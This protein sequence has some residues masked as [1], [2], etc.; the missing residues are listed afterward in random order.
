MTRANPYANFSLMQPLNTFAT[1]AQDGLDPTIVE[2]IKI[3]ASQINGCGMC[4]H[5]HTRDAL[6]AGET[7]ERIFLLD[8]WHDSPLFTDAER[9]VL[10]WTHV[11]TVITEPA[12]HDAAYDA[13]SA[14][15]TPDQQ[16]KI[17]LLIGAIN[18]Y[19][20][21]NIGFRVR[22]PVTQREAA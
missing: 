3:R 11:L 10:A 4:L 2:L 14:H 7:P 17:T 13:L 22:H 21:L 6:H 15:F 8:G 1:A 19:N 5:L 12:D 16:V 18:A 9:A 20:R